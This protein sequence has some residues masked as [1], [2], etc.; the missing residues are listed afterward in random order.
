[1]SYQITSDLPRL[2]QDLRRLRN[3]MVATVVVCTAL[4]AAGAAALVL[5]RTHAIDAR[6][7]ARVAQVREGVSKLETQLTALQ[8]IM[9]EQHRVA[10]EA[11]AT[12]PVRQADGDQRTDAGDR[13]PVSIRRR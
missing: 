4:A 3:E 10:V 6:I 9:E 12:L 5:W 2:E 7:D 11:A 1:M 8:G 13:R